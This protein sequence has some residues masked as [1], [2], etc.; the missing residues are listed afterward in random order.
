MEPIIRAEPIAS[1]N[2]TNHPNSFS[3]NP[4]GQALNVDDA[5]IDGKEPFAYG[6]ND[7]NSKDDYRNSTLLGPRNPQ[8]CS[9]QETKKSNDPQ[10]QPRSPTETSYD[11]MANP[12]RLNA[13]QGDGTNASIIRSGSGGEEG[14]DLRQKIAFIQAQ[15]QG[16]EHMRIEQQELLRKLQNQLDDQGKGV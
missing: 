5:G 7:P 9:P 11:F 15:N 12:Q 16:I 8:E 3:R 4:Q 2:Y 10:Y 6:D 13:P 1:A 14:L